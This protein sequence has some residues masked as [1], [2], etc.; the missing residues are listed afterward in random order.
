MQNER[1]QGSAELYLDWYYNTKPRFSSYWHQID[2][3]VRLAPST[4]L[5]IGV[6]SGI[7][8]H[9]LGELGITITSVDILTDLQPSTVAHIRSLPFADATFDVGLCCQVLEHV[10]YSESKQALREIRRVVRKGAVIS[11]PDRTHNLQVQV[12]VPYIRFHFDK[13]FERIFPFREELMIDQH[14]WELGVKDVSLA[15]I[16][17]DIRQAGFAIQKHFRVQE[18]PYHRFFVLACATGEDTASAGQQRG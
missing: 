8:K 2:E 16:M 1:E 11:V 18:F 14:Y 7:V 12:S 3:V 9:V 10:P 13:S 15:Q 6:G 4:L 17:Q 5:E